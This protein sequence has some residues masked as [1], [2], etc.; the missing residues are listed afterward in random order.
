M[1]LLGPCTI[2]ASNPSV[3]N[4]EPSVSMI[5]ENVPIVGP[6]EPSP[7]G[8]Q[9][10][11]RRLHYKASWILAPLLFNLYQL[12]IVSYEIIDGG[13]GGYERFGKLHLASFDVESCD[14]HVPG[15]SGGLLRANP[16]K[17]VYSVSHLE[18]PSRIH[19]ISTSSLNPSMTLATPISP[20]AQTLSPS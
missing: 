2:R 18:K 7:S 19:R 11:I 3:K 1:S 4:R 15:C 14:L 5:L 12:L 17:N 10:D 9:K 13:G 6:S 16:T 8:E 20:S